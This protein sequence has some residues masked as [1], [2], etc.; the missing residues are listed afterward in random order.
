ML[1]RSEEVTRILRARGESN[2]QVLPLVYDELRAIAQGR[3][4]SERA[5]HTLQATAL[6]HEAYVK[7]VGEEDLDWADRG[8]FYA[9]ASEAMRRILIDHAR[10]VRSLK[11]GGAHA[12]VTLGADEV[13]ADFDLDTMI[14]LGE[15]LTVLESEDERAS[16]VARLRF[17]AGLSV[18]ETA[19]ALGISERSVGRGWAYAQARLF[20][21]LGDF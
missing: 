21:L 11:R 20:E 7:L 5:D 6:V 19:N 15:A 4:F 1:D 12:R 13:R 14:A 17:L 8:D 16:A 9:A 2:D 10:K 18:Q 3:M